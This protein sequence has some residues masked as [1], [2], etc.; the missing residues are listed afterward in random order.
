MESRVVEL[1]LRFMKLER[2]TQELSDVVAQQRQKI[3]AMTVEIQRLRARIPR[4]EGE[5]PSNENPPHY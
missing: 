4:E 1:E 3:D 5:G 2:F